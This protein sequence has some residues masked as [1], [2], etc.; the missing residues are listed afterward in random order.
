[1]DSPGH[2]DAGIAQGL[3]LLIASF[4]C[5]TD[6]DAKSIKIFQVVK[7]WTKEG[8]RYT[9]VLKK[10]EPDK[11]A[12][13]YKYSVLTK[14][15]PHQYLL[16]VHDSPGWKNAHGAAIYFPKEYNYDFRTCV[17]TW[18][19]DTK[20]CTYWHVNAFVGI[21]PLKAKWSCK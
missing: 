6:D 3:V 5:D 16:V 10:Y 12:H 19:S 8:S 14:T 4:C 13:P 7:G 20:A 15:A 2:Y 21:S 17:G 18:S 1:M 11:G 9:E